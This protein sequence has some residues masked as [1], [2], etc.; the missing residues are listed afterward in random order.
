MNSPSS[1]NQ[2]SV[3]QRLTQALKQAKIQLEEVE[4]AKKEPIAI[5]GV[6]CRFPGGANDPETFW[7]ILRDGVD[8]ITPIPG[9]RWNI[10]EYYDPNPD[11]LGKIYTRNGGFLNQIDQ[12]D[13]QFFGISPREAHSLDPQQRL[14]LEVTWEALENAGQPVQDLVGSN[15]GVFIGIGQNDYAQKQLNAGNPTRIGTYDGTGNGFCFAS[16]RLSY[17]LGLLGPNMAVDT[18]CS[19]SLVSIHLA[20]QSLRAGECNLALAGGVQLILSPEVTLFLS[21]AHA[22][23]PDG[24][25]KTFDADAN[26]YGRGEGCG[27]LVLKRLSDAVANG[28][29]ILALIRGSAVN[30]NGISSGLTVPNK[31]AQEEL[32]RQALANAR[33][34]PH[35]VDYVEAHGTGT[36]LGDPIEVRALGTVYGKERSQERPLL[37]GSVK[38]NIGHL[39]AAAGVAG[40]IKVV[41]ALQHKHI[42]PHLHY[43]KPNPHINWQQLPI[44]V[45]QSLASWTSDKPRLAAVSSFGIS[46]TNAHLILESAPEQQKLAIEE[47]R[48]LHLFTLTAKTPTALKQLAQSY[49]NSLG[50]NP[51]LAIGDLCF[52]ANTGRSHLGHRLSVVAASTSEL[53]KKLTAFVTGQAVAG[54]SQKQISGN[55]SPKIAFLFTGQGSQYVNMGRQLYETHPGFRQILDYCA[56]ILQPYLERPLL[57]ILYPPTSE[58]S[59]LDAAESQLQ[60]TAYTQPALFALEYALYQVWK[61]WGIEPTVVMGHSVGEYVA[62]CVAGVF[63]LED[64]LK[65]IAHRAR[66]MQS[67][68]PNGTMVAVFAE[69][70]QVQEVIQPYSNQVAIAAINGPQH[71]VISGESQAIEAILTIL[72]AK[73]ITT[74]QLKVSHAFHSPQMEP[75]LAEFEQVARQ[76]TYSTPQIE[77]ISNLTGQPANQSIAT[78]EYWCT[79]VRQAVQF[80]TS[81][82]T[83]IEKGCELLVEIGAKPTLLGMIRHCLT[84]EMMERVALLPSLRANTD[85]WQQL[86]QSLGELY[87]HGVSIDWVE[88]DQYYSRSRLILPNYPFER[89]RYWIAASQRQFTTKI[90]PLLSSKFQS[91]LLQETLFES[92]CS[93]DELPFLQDHKVYEQV[94]VPGAFH[95]ALLLG[96]SE[97][98]FNTKGSIL[99]DVVFTQAMV[100]PET[101]GRKL[102]LSIT[103][104][105]H[106][107][108]TFELI[109]SP[110]Q[111]TNVKS[112]WTIHA[113]GNCLP[114][115]QSIDFIEPVSIS[116]ILARCPQE[117]S[118]KDLYTKLSQRQI[119]LGSSFQWLRSLWKGEQEILGKLEL[120]DTL[121]G[122]EEYQLHPSLIDACFQLLVVI[123]PIDGTETVVPLKIQQFRFY[124][125]PQTS[126]LWAYARIHGTETTN[127]NSL[128]SDVQLLDETGQVIAEIEGFEGKIVTPESLLR[129][130][131]SDLYQDCYKVVWQPQSLD[132][133]REILPQTTSRCWLILAD[134]GGKGRSLAHF[135]AKDGDHCILVFPGSNYQ[136]LATNHYQLNPTVAADFQRLLTEI[137]LPADAILEVVHLWSLDTNTSSATLSSALELSCGSGLH[138]VQAIAQTHSFKN[139]K[140]WLITQGC[141][142]VNDNLTDIC[143]QQS[144]VW[145]LGQVIRLEHP[146][147]HCVNLDLDPKEQ[148][149]DLYSLLIELAATN[150]EDQ[151]AYRQGVRYIPQL[152]RLAAPTS[153]KP[154]EISADGSYLIT[155]GLGA[156]GLEVANWLAAQGAGTLVLTGR[157]KANSATQ[158]IIQ[159]IEETGTQVFVI[160]ADVSQPESVAQLL[161]KIKQNLPPLRGIIHAAGVLDDGVLLQQTWERFQLVTAPKIAGAWN[162]HQLTQNISLD[163]FVCFSSVAS[164]L[165]SPGQANYAA[166]NAFLDALAH[167]RQGLGKSSLSINWGP[168]SEA[169]MATR[170]SNS[171]QQRWATQGITP[172]KPDKGLQTLEKL[173]QQHHAQ[174]GVVAINW[175]EFGKQIAGQRTPSL[176]SELMSSVRQQSQPSTYVVQKLP[177]RES[178]QNISP[179]ERKQKLIKYVQSTVAHVLGLS[180][181]QLDNKQPLNTMGLDSLMT[182]ELKNRL[183]ADLGVD[184]PIAQLVEEVTIIDLV[185]IIQPQL[186]ESQVDDASASTPNITSTDTKELFSSN[187][188]DL[189]D[190]VALLERIEQLTD[191][192]VNTWLHSLLS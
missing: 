28:D 74:K 101:G 84:P 55:R 41:L 92:D 137:S 61:S 153:E 129:Q 110:D 121:T 103:P 163:F 80:A 62:A 71:C 169:G 42:P 5:V 149:I 44:K 65:L 34:S 112:S 136:N 161:Q 127:S 113:T 2:A 87:V 17:I 81:V 146:N 3:S 174:V 49:I 185:H 175:S 88:F 9:D 53:E 4:R 60:A 144:A 48:P 166:A 151:I 99:Q 125:R 95:L 79:H 54:V 52:S 182:V 63:S 105:E 75:M 73:Q 39:E 68:Q 176:I 164:L 139:V 148:A 159:Q 132:R 154:V 162:L 181:N 116:D 123:L 26:G 124:Q 178:W 102:H 14:L 86:L 31:Q 119:Q 167:Y 187:K 45:A 38:T 69:E 33:V 108:S 77:L 15:T 173:L 138:L 32:I 189:S 16:G 170:L 22:L 172:I 168:W 135:L 58:E 143:V 150:S 120:P 184:V 1:I 130:L 180:A 160:S 192:Q 118:G 111:N 157:K 12:F 107:G 183:Q 171:Q 117:I 147:I 94:V 133:T 165:G 70:A 158:Q 43:Q 13:P 152:V 128:I 29:H 140:L 90:H 122:V 67:L 64:G 66:L 83:L 47:Q 23:S 18:A 85:D 76:I 7:Q 25:C 6:G 145:G 97:L 93:L 126:H 51:S 46:G 114:N 191:E 104:N 82:D 131:Q 186:E 100:M 115:H 19:S 109:S 37:I 78:S 89:Q 20:C 11:T 156:L 36:I 56:E 57:E 188:I 10:D 142:A 35:E 40:L 21:R 8:T 96:A 190:S 72:Q 50:S 177:I 155:G 141:Q 24:R 59:Q 27:I 30:H 98:T 134:E 91:P 106:S 179:T